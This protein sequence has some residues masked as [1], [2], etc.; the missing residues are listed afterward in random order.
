MAQPVLWDSM[1]L[2]GAAVGAARWEGLCRTCSAKHVNPK[3][4]S[5]TSVLPTLSFSPGSPSLG[6]LKFIVG[7]WEPQG[8]EGTS[9]RMEE[10]DVRAWDGTG[11]VGGAGGGRNILKRQFERCT[12]AA[13]AGGTAQEEGLLLLAVY[14]GAAAA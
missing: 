4:A 2:A 11:W 10:W 12:C 9:H 8:W 14:C 5:G 3:A 13:R 6:A 1:A 7:V